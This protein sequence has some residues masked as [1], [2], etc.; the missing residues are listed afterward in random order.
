[1]NLVNISK[2][3]NENNR[4]YTYRVLKENIMRLN[5]KPGESISEIELSEALDAVSYTHLTLP[6]IGG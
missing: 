2:H 1:M 6:T 4:A 3:K 5:L